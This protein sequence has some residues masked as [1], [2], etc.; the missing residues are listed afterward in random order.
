[1]THAHPDRTECLGQIEINPAPSRTQRE[2]LEWCT[3]RGDE[4]GDEVVWRFCAR[5]CCLRVAQAPDSRSAAAALQEVVDAV[6]RSGHRC[7]GL[8][9]VRRGDGET[10]TLRVGR[11]RVYVKVLA[12]RAAAEPR[13]AS[14]TPLETRRSSARARVH[15]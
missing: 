4:V 8:L 5:G 3:G 13:L 12:G 7:T 9:V 14:V 1:M 15:R 6:A 2:E 10:F 11:G